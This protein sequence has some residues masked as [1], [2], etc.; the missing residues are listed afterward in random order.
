MVYDR[1]YPNFN[2]ILA[3]SPYYQYKI[4]GG[5]PWHLPQELKSF[6]KH[7]SERTVEFPDVPI[8]VMGRKTY[9]SIGKPLPNRQ[10]V[11]FTTGKEKYP[12]GVLTFSTRK[13]LLAY[14]FTRN[15]ANVW[16]IGGNA[17]WYEFLPFCKRVIHTLVLACDPRPN[18]EDLLSV[19]LIRNLRF[20][21]CSCNS[22]QKL[23]T[24]NDEYWQHEYI[25]T[26]GIPANLLQWWKWHL[27]RPEI[28]PKG[29][30]KW[31]LYEFL[32]R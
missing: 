4:D 8:L 31:S 21:E 24:A 14:L 9:E 3:T 6:K 29:L 32:K 20:F 27:A 22:H 2:L 13:E 11:V 7:T 15:K 25:N 12:E 5:L 1:I 18:P 23:L 30:G 19:E 16:F 17:I 26:S 28:K 10:T